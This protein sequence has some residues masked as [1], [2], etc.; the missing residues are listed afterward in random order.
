[1]RKLPPRRVLRGVVE[2][3]ISDREGFFDPTIEEETLQAIADYRSV[4]PKLSD[5]APPLTKE[6]LAIIA[7]A[8]THA[9]YWRDSYLDAYAGTNDKPAILAAKQDIERLEKV[10]EALGVK[11]HW[12]MGGTLPEGT[13]LVSVF[14]LMKKDKSEFQ[15][16]TI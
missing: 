4:L 8:C 13:R 3:A 7:K 6:T 10:E 5:K 11:V 14:D 16:E 15:Q 12:T 2:D 9:R 1:M